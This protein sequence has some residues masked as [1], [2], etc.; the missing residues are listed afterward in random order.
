LFV[1]GLVIAGAVSLESLSFWLV[2]GLVTGAVFLLAYIFVL[3]FRLSLLPL[4]LGTLTILE[5]VKQ[6]MYQAYPAAL[7]GAFLA[8][9]LVG[10]LSIYWFRKLETE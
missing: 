2:S 7:P 8:G 5:E 10:L 9:V 4:I 1:M 3:R 6:G